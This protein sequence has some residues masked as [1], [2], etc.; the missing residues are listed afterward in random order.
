MV[1]ALRRAGVD[2]WVIFS[3]SGYSA[4]FIS[5]IVSLYFF[6]LYR[7]F[8][9]TQKIE[10]EHPLTTSNY[11]EFFYISAPFLGGIAGCFSGIDTTISEFLLEISIAS[12]GTAFLVWVAIDPIAG[13]IEILTPAGLRHRS[14]R[15]AQARAEREKRQREREL[16]LAGVLKKEESNLR[17]QKEKLAPLAEKLTELLTVKAKGFEGAK[18]KAALMGLKAWQIGGLSG[19]QQ[20]RDM[21][22]EICS[23]KYKD[24]TI[25]DYIS[26]WWDGIGNWRNPSLC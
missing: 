7:V 25:V 14:E 4:F 5:L 18:E 16:L 11:Y 2:W 8:A 13:C 17:N 20:L 24:S 3:L 21:T 6:A 22:M 10:I 23:K 12:L 19:M 1:L 15:L 9:G 26:T